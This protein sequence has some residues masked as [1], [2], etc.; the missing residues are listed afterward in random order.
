MGMFKHKS[1]YRLDVIIENTSKRKD[2][3]FLIQTAAGYLGTDDA[4]KSR[5]LMIQWLGD[6][7]FSEW[8]R[9]TIF[10]G[11]WGLGFAPAR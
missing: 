1:P 8:L 11:V 3:T 4:Q 10:T 6:N 9:L 7:E 5:E 2:D